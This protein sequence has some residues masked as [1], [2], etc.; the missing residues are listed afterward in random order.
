MLHCCFRSSWNLPF[1]GIFASAKEIGCSNCVNLLPLWNE[2]YWSTALHFWEK[3]ARAVWRSLLALSFARGSRFSSAD[4][5]PDKKSICIPASFR[6][7]GMFAASNR[8]I[9]SGL[10]LGDSCRFLLVIFIQVATKCFFK[11]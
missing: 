11:N 2:L 1:T 10:K 8:A 4:S 3:L 9:C 7:V 5:Q 6:V